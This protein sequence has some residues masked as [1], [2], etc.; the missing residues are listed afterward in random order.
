MYKI[1]AGTLSFFKH[2][3]SLR[4]KFRSHTYTIVI[5]VY[6]FLT[7]R[8]AGLN[9][10]IG[11]K[12]RIHA[13]VPVFVTEVRAVCVKYNQLPVI[14]LIDFIVKQRQKSEVIGIGGSIRCFFNKYRSVCLKAET[15]YE[16]VIIPLVGKKAVLNPASL[17]AVI[18]LLT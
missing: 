13:F 2:S 6:E 8:F 5:G 3:G 12:H 7:K 9:G 4:N 15:V 18:I 14:S 16:R 10:I 11:R 1:A 17:N